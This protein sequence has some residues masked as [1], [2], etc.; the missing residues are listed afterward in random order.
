MF[1]PYWDSLQAVV[2]D[3]PSSLLCVTSLPRLNSWDPTVVMVDMLKHHSS[4]G[5][6]QTSACVLLVMGDR[7]R[8]LTTLDEAVQEHWLLAYIDILFRLQL[9]DVTTKV[10]QLAWIPMV[11]QLNQ[12]STTV[13]T[14]CSRCNKPLLRSGWI[15]D[16]CHTSECAACS[17]CHKVVRGIWQMV[18]EYTRINSGSV[19]AFSR[20]RLC[21]A[22]QGMRM[23]LWSKC[24]CLTKVDK[25]GGVEVF[26]LVG[27]TLRLKRKSKAVAFTLMPSFQKRGT[28]GGDKR[29]QPATAVQNYESNSNS[30]FPLPLFPHTPLVY[31]LNP[32]RDIRPTPLPSSSRTP[33]QLQTCTFIHDSTTP[34]PGKSRPWILRPYNKTIHHL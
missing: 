25:G 23:E 12:Q 2:E 20:E 31:P 24:G 28:R 33:L 15:C 3:Q 6:V 5:D 7:R 10:I 21:S 27:M 16:R 30:L 34:S 14:G 9:W 29:V 17:V 19:V 8:T 13:Y 26:Q 11:C 4:L 22:R 18:P 1:P 32:P